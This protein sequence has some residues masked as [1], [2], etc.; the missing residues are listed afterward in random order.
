LRDP[1]RG[2][3][4]RRLEAAWVGRASIGLTAVYV[5]A[6]GAAEL[7]AEARTELHMRVI[8]ALGYGH[9]LAS[10]VRGQAHGR[11]RGPAT[12]ASTRRLRTVLALGSAYA[13]Y[14]ELCQLAPQLPLALLALSAWHTTENHRA[15]ARSSLD[16]E[17]PIAALSR[18][19][20]D[21]ILDGLAGLAF[22]MLGVVL[23]RCSSHIEVADVVAAFSLHHLLSWLILNLARA[24]RRGRIAA[25]LGFLARLH[26]PMI[27]L[28][29][30]AIVVVESRTPL[31]TP[32]LLLAEAVLSPATYLFWS[33]AHVAHT[34]W[35]RC[36]R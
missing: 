25:M 2:V 30:A 22:G 18:A 3:R 26:A 12:H 15:M 28:C 29:V 14:V 10:V 24:R 4:R 7:R 36:A 23:A 21:W 32:L 5:L 20:G 34:A 19:R 8:F 31:P 33:A 16:D 27:A 13:I 11:G 17:R 9:L 1:V 6:T 35:R